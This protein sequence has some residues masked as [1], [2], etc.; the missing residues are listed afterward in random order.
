VSRQYYGIDWVNR[1]VM[2]DVYPRKSDP[3]V[4]PSYITPPSGTNQP[5]VEEPGM[6]QNLFTPAITVPGVRP[7]VYQRAANLSLPV[8]D[9]P[10]AIQAGT[11]QCDAILIN[12]PSSSLNSTFF[13]FGSGISSTNGGIEVVPGVPQFFSPTNVREQWELQRLLEAITAMLGE[14]ISL[15][16]G[17][18]PGT[19]PGTPGQFMS[20][21]VVMNAHDYYLVNAATISQNVSVMLFTVPEMQ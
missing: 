9:Q 19:N 2:P 18:G 12:V 17:G 3:F 5:Q 4:P 10:I 11:F 13:G 1:E 14:L 20:P 6:A 21:R 7:V 8:T 15:Q 16:L